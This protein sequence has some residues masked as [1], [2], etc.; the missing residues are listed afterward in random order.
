MAEE[1]GEKFR[2]GQRHVRG[3]AEERGAETALQA[4]G[5]HA[6]LF[7]RTAGNETKVFCAAPGRFLRRIKSCHPARGRKSCHPARGR[8]DDCPLDAPIAQLDR[9]ADYGIKILR[10]QDK[11]PHYNK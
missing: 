9:A 7:M 5:R 6:E 11:T 2:D 3:E 8:Y 1:S 4:G 10:F